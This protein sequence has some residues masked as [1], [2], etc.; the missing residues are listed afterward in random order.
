MA[1]LMR[2]LRFET[3]RLELV[4]VYVPVFGKDSEGG[5]HASV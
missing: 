3:Y 2:I 4:D 5:A 1:A